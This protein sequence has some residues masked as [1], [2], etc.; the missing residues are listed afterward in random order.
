VESKA[1]QKL[2]DALN[3]AKLAEEKTKLRIQ[4][5]KEMRDIHLKRAMDMEKKIGDLEE[6]L[7]EASQPPWDPTTKTPPL[8]PISQLR[9]DEPGR[10]RQSS[11]SSVGSNPGNEISHFGASVTGGGFRTHSSGGN[12]A[13][14]T[15]TSQDSRAYTPNTGLLTRSAQSAEALV[16]G[17]ASSWPGVSGRGGGQEQA[18]E[19]AYLAA[20]GPNPDLPTAPMSMSQSRSLSNF[21]QAPSSA[22]C[23]FPRR[24]GS[25]RQ[26]ATPEW[27]RPS[28]LSPDEDE[29]LKAE[30]R[31]RIRREMKD[32][33]GNARVAFKKLD[34]NGSGSIS[35]QEFADGV[36]RLGI[37]WQHITGLKRN[38]DL[39]AMFDEDKDFKITF[40]E[41]F[42]EDA[43]E[44][45]ERPSTPEF[46]S[47]YN[48]NRNY[49]IKPSCWTPATCMEELRKSQD[50]YD[51][52]DDAARKRKWMCSTI[53]R[54][55][56]RGKSD[57]RCR[58]V[59]ALHLPR[60]TGPR[61]RE[62]V[63]TYSQADLK[64][65][66]KLYS[67]EVN[68]PIRRVT[69][70]VGDYKD[71]RREQKRIYDKLYSVTEMSRGGVPE[72]LSLRKNEDHQT[73]LGFNKTLPGSGDGG[74]AMLRAQGMD[75]EE[76]AE[77]RAEFMKYV[78]PND[79][80]G[81]RGFNRLLQAILPN[82]HFSQA[83]AETA[84]E[85]IQRRKAEE[86]K[87]PVPDHI[88]SRSHSQSDAY[89]SN[90][91]TQANVQKLHDEVGRSVRAGELA[92]SRQACTF[93]QFCSWWAERQAKRA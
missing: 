82:T 78:D 33:C 70:V 42:P 77:L 81:K 29:L 74:V 61:D 45:A 56:T 57:A 72:G 46:W 20:W 60:G 18:A 1:L 79:M 83:Q 35:C 31:R 75:N 92:R 50:T 54:L 41:L 15:T 93:E 21:P 76:I 65:T 91:A 67:D 32:M 51:R 38:R 40:A 36:S 2:D 19:A 52:I 88:E 17:M 86:G 44:R 87:A 24:C 13:A 7:I 11:I 53:R 23:T 68:L 4:K 10:G 27:A 66:R 37:D 14:S 34:L 63:C 6:K 26:V 30:G 9:I 5:H 62:G 22:P 69:K 90:K 47:M 64:N 3:G 73:A 48:K 55:K 25:L 16:S 58:E 89:H 84:W 71:Q 43:A 49:N 12:G 85:E 80:L 28:H 39:F 8:V 59:V